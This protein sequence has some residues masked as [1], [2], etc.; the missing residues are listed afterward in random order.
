[1]WKNVKSKQ[2]IEPAHTE[3]S[4]LL[5]N[6]KALT[7]CWLTPKKEKKKAALFPPFPGVLH[8]YYK[9]VLIPFL[10]TFTYLIQGNVIGKEM[11]E[12]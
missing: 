6:A 3:L 12:R 2:I 8:A 5:G 10:L 9:L 1:M 7:S 11:G 4:R